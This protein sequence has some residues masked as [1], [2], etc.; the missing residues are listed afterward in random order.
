MIAELKG[1]LQEGVPGSLKDD[2][3]GETCLQ[4][5]QIEQDPVISANLPSSNDM[6]SPDG[7]PMGGQSPNGAGLSDLEKSDL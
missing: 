1:R 4:F 5:S 6:L 3:S 7:F 2:T